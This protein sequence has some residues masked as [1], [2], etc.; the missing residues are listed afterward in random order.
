M[1]CNVLCATGVWHVLGCLQSYNWCSAPW[2]MSVG[3]RHQASPWLQL[4]FHPEDDVLCG[5]SQLPS[6]LQLAFCHVYICR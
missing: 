5:T 3:G 1:S 2:V 4:A 6:E